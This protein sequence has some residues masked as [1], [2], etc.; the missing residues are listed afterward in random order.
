MAKLHEAKVHILHPTQI[1]VGMIEVHDK[2]R[3]I[4]PM[5][6][7]EL[8]D[9]LAA[10]PMPA[11]RRADDE[12]Y[13][14]DHHHLGRALWEAGIE[15]A[16]VAIE[17]K[18]PEMG[19]MHF[20]QVM[21]RAHWAH[22]IDDKGVHQPYTD[23]PEHVKQLRDDDTV[24]IVVY[25]GAEHGFAAHVEREGDADEQHHGQRDAVYASY[26]ATLF[27]D[28]HAPYETLAAEWEG[29]LVAVAQLDPSDARL[30]ALDVTQVVIT[31]V[32]GSG[33][34]SLVHGSIPAGAGVVPGTVLM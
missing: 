20:W 22:P 1:T 34:S 5:K 23:I 15:D 16:F 13:I 27:V 24:G 29:R 11:V 10:H 30:R 3:E 9:F 31:G 2:I 8:R 17:E 28:T 33:K 32:A 25:A 6:P 18:L 12:L 19:L 26:A 14:T 21:I 4:S 7:H